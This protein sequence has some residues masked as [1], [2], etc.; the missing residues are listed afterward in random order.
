MTTSHGIDNKNDFF[1]K[2]CPWTGYRCGTLTR[3]EGDFGGSWG[4]N[5][6]PFYAGDKH[7]ASID[8]GK[9]AGLYIFAPRLEAAS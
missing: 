6:D 8:C 2:T 3:V 4:F 9:T 5:F 7:F 1:K